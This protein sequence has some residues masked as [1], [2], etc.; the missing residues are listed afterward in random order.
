MAIL[1]KIRQ[2]SIFLILVIGLA[3]FAFVISGVFDNSGSVS[4]SP[5]VATVNGEDISIAEFRGEVDA[6]QRRYGANMSSTQAANIVWNQKIRQAVLNGQF[7]ELG[8]DIGKDQLSD[9][10]T[11]NPGFASNPEFQNEAGLFDI[12]KY[13]DYLKDAKVNNVQA[14]NFYKQQEDYA[15]A[16][17][18]EQMYFNLIRAGVGGTFKDGELE[19][20]LEND[21]VDISFVQIPYSSIADSTVQIT[22]GEIKKYIE[23]HQDD[24]QVE[25][26]RDL[27]FV[28]FEDKASKEDEVNIEADITALLDDT[29]EYNDVSKLN[30]SIPGF[31]NAADVDEFLAKHSDVKYD[32]IFKAKKD[33]PAVFADS[34]FNLEKG[35]IYGPYRDGEYFKLTKMID[36]KAEGSVKASHILVAY[37]G[38]TRAAET[39]TRTKEEAEARAKE[40]LAEVKGDVEKFADVARANSDGPS[41]SQGGDLGYFEEGAMVKDFNDFVFGNAVGAVD[42]VETEFGFHVIKVDDKQDIVRVATLAKEVESSEK[43]QNAL[44]N[45]ASKFEIAAGETGDFGETAKTSNYNVRRADNVKEL[46]ENLPGMQS[47]RGIVQWAFNPETKIG[48][49]KRFQVNG[50]YAVV[51]VTGATEAGLSSVEDAS[52]RVLP[53]LKK[54]K[55]AKMIMD[56]NADAIELTALA[57]ANNTTVRT[58]SALNMKN[59]TI[60]GA[61]REPKVVGAAFGL[62]Q[63]TVSDFIEGE[64]GVY[65]IAVNR[66]EKAPDL[67]SYAAYA[68]TVKGNLKSRA[69]NAAYNALKDAADI[70]DNRAEFY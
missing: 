52:A 32:S 57:T 30:D 66:V 34:I 2:R 26:A 35:A 61:T 53:I 65:K 43:T 21:K 50:G 8:L 23:S 51:Q 24:F 38:A 17:A 49:I 69:N 40:L 31:K 58:A 12:N 37:K 19:Y 41:K 47:Q 11:N 67:P 42:L 60:P 70:E 46:D 64:A 25:D 10:I 56:K 27:Q 9:L 13:I 33:L 48:D 44:F 20:R 15:V 14:Y 55:K 45:T 39:V 7:D 63:G 28:V 4:T 22:K 3:L 1:G 6:A 36:K 54:Q 29:V 62:G 68:N 59:P 18:K 5:N 16:A